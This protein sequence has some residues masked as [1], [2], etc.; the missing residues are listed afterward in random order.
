[1]KTSDGHGVI[2][3]LAASSPLESS[4]RRLETDAHDRRGELP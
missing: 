3:R 1:V 4:S 2:A